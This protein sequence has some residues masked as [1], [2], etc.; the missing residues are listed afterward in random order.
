[1]ITAHGERHVMADH[2][3]IAIIDYRH[4][5]NPA[6]GENEPLRRIYDGGK[7]VDAHAAQI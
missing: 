4:L 3:L 7:T 5:G 6:N 1:M 2:D